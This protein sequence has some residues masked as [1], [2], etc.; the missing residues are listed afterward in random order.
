M[1]TCPWCGTQYLSFQSNCQKCG[2][3]LHAL[4]QSDLGQILDTDLPI[5][6]A[7]PR[8][9]SGSY[10][11]HL[12]SA[13]GWWIVAFIFGLLGAIFS[14]VGIGL[15]LAIITALIGIIFLFLGLAFLVGGGGVFIWRYQIARK[16]VDVLRDGIA[17]SGTITSLEQNFS[18][19]MNGRSPWV[20]GYA[21]RV[22]NQNYTA[23]VSTLNHPNPRQQIGS[24]V[25]VL[26]L[27]S[28]PTCC[29][30]YPHP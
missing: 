19:R 6:P 2:G 7:P 10:V 16:V 20:F 8:P 12:L 29:S 11:W 23:Q 21:Y 1:I 5:P 27:A 14:L 4:A 3:P 15:T 25:T 30:I 9:I 28:E 22:N 17:T 18:V 26:Y 13:D 24:P